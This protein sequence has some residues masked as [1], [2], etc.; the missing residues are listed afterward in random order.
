[1]PDLTGATSAR[2]AGAAS[3]LPPSLMLRGQLKSLQSRPDGY[4]SLWGC[5]LTRVAPVAGVLLRA[6]ATNAALSGS[7]HTPEQSEPVR[8]SQVAAVL[9]AVLLAPAAA[10]ARSVPAP[11]Q[12]AVRLL[13][14]VP[15]Y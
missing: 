6:I 1:M 14:L 3:T 9:G 4:G 12:Q 11:H 13:R 5:V 15:A 10:R 7:R 8:W 2:R